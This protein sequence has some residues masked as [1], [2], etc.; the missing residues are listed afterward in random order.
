VNISIISPV[1]LL[2]FKGNGHVLF[3]RE[4]L[5]ETVT[6]LSFSESII[7][8]S[9]LKRHRMMGDEPLILQGNLSQFDVSGGSTACTC[10]ALLFARLVL[11]SIPTKG[12]LD[13]IVKA[14]GK[15]WLQ[16]KHWVNQQSKPRDPFM[17]T[18]TEVSQV[19]PLLL[20]GMKQRS[21]TNGYVG[22]MTNP[23]M[24]EKFL[25]KSIEEA[26]EGVTETSTTSSAVLTADAS[27]F[28]IGY[29]EKRLFFF[30]SHGDMCGGGAT[31]T[32]FPNIQ[33]LSTHLFQTLHADTQFYL[34]VFDKYNSS[35]TP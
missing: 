28:G 24:R 33:K 23:S 8:P 27:S 29:Y 20:T 18:W 2:G 9:I 3:V 10:T 5:N 21:E 16:W 6:L 31:I 11:E 35:G 19:F 25:L 4:F 17:P 15:L 12:E 22:K 1:F 14:G 7:R 34:V 32:E 26:L 13:K 30:D